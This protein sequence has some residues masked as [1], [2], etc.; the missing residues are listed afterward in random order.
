[1]NRIARYA[2]L[3]VVLAAGLLLVACGGDESEDRPAAEA[4]PD[5]FANEFPPLNN[6]IAEVGA[7]VR[8]IIRRAERRPPQRLAASLGDAADEV[9]EL[10]R[11][12]EDLRVPETLSPQRD[13]VVVAIRD[14][15]RALERMSV[16]ASVNRPPPALRNARIALV[17]ALRALNRTRSTLAEGMRAAENSG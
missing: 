8:N 10:R 17:E 6:R 5:R 4:A 9:G 11:E 12:V 3:L 7:E 13:V 15:R 14:V 1:M 2:T 16:V